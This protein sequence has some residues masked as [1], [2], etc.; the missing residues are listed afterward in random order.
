MLLLQSLLLDNLQED[1]DTSQLRLR[2]L[3]RKVQEVIKR[4][5]QDRQL[6]LILVLSVVLV[7]LTVVALA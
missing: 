4:S 3:R 7:V 6:C 5:R 2:G 1:T